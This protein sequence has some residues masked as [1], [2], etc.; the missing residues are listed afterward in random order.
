MRANI[1]QCL[2]QG[3]L[4]TRAKA[5]SAAASGAKSDVYTHRP[6]LKVCMTNG[7]SRKEVEKAGITIRHAITKI[8]TR[9]R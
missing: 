7:L 5:L 8:M 1:P 4:V 9:K 6:A 2:A 3:V